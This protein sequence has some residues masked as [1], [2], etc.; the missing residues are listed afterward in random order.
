MAFDELSHYYSHLLD[1]SYDCVDRIVL[2]A[3]FGL[4]YSAGG[5]RT[6]WRRLHG[7]SDDELDNAHLMRMAGRFSRRVRG[8]ARANGVP[9]IDCGSE[10]RKHRIAEEHMKKNPDVRGVLF[11]VLV[12][13]APFGRSRER[14]EG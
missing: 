3:H 11:L 4:A 8:W 6:W 13:R 5:F 9:V 14:P 2:N 12:G 1:G 7:G 10:E